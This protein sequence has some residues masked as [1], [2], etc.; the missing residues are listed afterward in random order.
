VLLFE[1]L[2]AAR[3]FVFVP[4]TIPSESMLP[5]LVPRDLIVVDR[6]TFGVAHELPQRGD[7]VA[8]RV[9][10]EEVIHVSR[11]VGMPGDRFAYRDD[12]VYIDGVAVELSNVEPY[13]FRGHGGNV[14]EGHLG[15]AV[16]RALDRADGFGAP[17]SEL[18]IPDGQY[19]MLGDNRD[20]A[21][22]SRYVG[23]IPRELLVGR[24]DTR[25]GELRS[26]GA[27]RRPAALTTRCADAF[28]KH[29]PPLSTKRKSNEAAVRLGASCA[30]AGS[31]PRTATRKRACRKLRPNPKLPH[32]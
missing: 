7:V 28:R 4:F 2:L 21:R 30:P 5:T 1:G 25:R 17:A 6:Y 12:T 10:R 3:F 24:R 16:F 8:F 32:L 9:P 19:F 27:S 31:R 15:D 14:H 11:V 18:Q 26:P 20:N 29:S 13:I 22:D 23:T